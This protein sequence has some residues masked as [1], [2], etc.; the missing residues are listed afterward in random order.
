M[1]S[2]WKF[3]ARLVSPGRE[4]KREN[5]STEKVSP[6][7]LPSSG[8][9]ETPVEDSLNSDGRPAGEE[10]PRHGQPG[11]ISLKPV[12]SEGAENDVQDKVDGEVA[13]I[14]EGADPAISGGT[15]IDF[16]AAHDAARIKRTAEVRPREQ[17]S[18]SKE[19]VAIANDP[20]VIHTANEMSLDDEIRV[21]RDQL[22]RK[23]TLQNAQLRKML[24]RFER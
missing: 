15:G 18:R 4:Q 19:A 12:R 13:K 1:A 21:L 23:L 2:P 9:T 8:S 20:Q 11:A 14:V 10:L 5:G 7:A 6:E 3:L 22:A 16:T 17:R 24:E